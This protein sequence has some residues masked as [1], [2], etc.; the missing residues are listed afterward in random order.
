[1][2]VRGIAIRPAKKKQSQH[3]ICRAGKVVEKAVPVR[4]DSMMPKGLTRLRN[5]STRDVLAHIS[6]MMLCS[7]TST[8]LAPNWF[9]R[10]CSDCKCW[11]RAR[12]ASL[13]VSGFAPSSATVAAAWTAA[14]VTGDVDVD[15]GGGGEVAVVVVGGGGGGRVD[16]SNWRARAISRSSLV[17][18]ACARCDARGS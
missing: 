16:S 1:M 14:A 15:G 7:L 6:K 2:G 8:I 11:C 3:A 12:S 17:C 13:G 5:A 4:A 18:S 9:A 10:T